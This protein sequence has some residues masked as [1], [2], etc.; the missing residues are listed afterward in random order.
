MISIWTCLLLI[1]IAVIVTIIFTIIK[2][3]KRSEI[4]YKLYCGFYEQNKRLYTQN[5]M[6]KIVLEMKENRIKQLEKE[7]EQ[8]KRGFVKCE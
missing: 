1:F 7:K 2:E 8:L 3:R 4:T 5:A 6:T